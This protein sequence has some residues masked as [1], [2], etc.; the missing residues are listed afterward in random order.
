LINGTLVSSVGAKYGVS[1]SQVSLKYLVQFAQTEYGYAG[2][3]PK[4][5]DPAHLASNIDLFHFTLSDSDMALLTSATAPPG[6][7]GD[8]DAP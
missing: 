1:G 2:V 3:I 8:C 5:T 4:S 7:L 6:E